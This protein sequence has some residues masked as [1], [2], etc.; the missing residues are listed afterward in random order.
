MN[1]VFKIRTHIRYNH[2]KKTPGNKTPISE[3]FYIQAGA[4]VLRLL[5]GSMDMWLIS[6]ESFCNSLDWDTQ[7]GLLLFLF[8]RFS[9]VANI[10]LCMLYSIQTMKTSQIDRSTCI[11]TWGGIYN[12]KINTSFTQIITYYH[13]PSYVLFLWSTNVSTHQNHPEPLVKHR[14]LGPASSFQFSRLEKRL[15]NFHFNRFPGSTEAARSSQDFRTLYV[16]R[17]EPHKNQQ[18]RANTGLIW[19]IKKSNL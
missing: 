11:Y 3:Y 14:L 12:D 4:G 1:S 7:E 19:Q 18:R 10:L 8:I 15:E 5:G 9:S 17:R 16:T 6:R 2:R 13:I